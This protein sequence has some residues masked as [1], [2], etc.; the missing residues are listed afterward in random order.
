MLIE[1]FVDTVRDGFTRAV[2]RV[3][4]RGVLSSGTPTGFD[5]LQRLS[6]DVIGSYGFQVVTDGLDSTVLEQLRISVDLD[7]R[8][9]G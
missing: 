5:E 3:I 4:V 2:P 1:A 7:C 8:I 9:E 6:S